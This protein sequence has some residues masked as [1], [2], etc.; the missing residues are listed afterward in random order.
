MNHLWGLPLF[1]LPGSSSFTLL[2]PTHP[3]SLVCTSK[4]SR[5][6]SHGLVS[7]PSQGKPL[8]RQLCPLLSFCQCLQTL[9]HS[10]S[11]SLI[12]S[13][14]VSQTSPCFHRYI[15]CTSCL[16]A[17]HFYIFDVCHKQF[18]NEFKMIF[19]LKISS[20][21]SKHWRLKII[22]QLSAVHACY[23]V[24]L[25]GETAVCLQKHRAN[26]SVPALP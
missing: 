1:L 22:P 9:H 23:C 21:E 15:I 5:C 26:P 11:S 10:S 18:F 4:P 14:P 20:A 25:S 17:P 16:S 6:P 12:A 8:H 19:F 3:L 2:S 24:H 13:R 7:N